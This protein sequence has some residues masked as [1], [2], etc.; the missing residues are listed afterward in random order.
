MQAVSAIKM[1]VNVK[2]HFIFSFFLLEREI[3]QSRCFIESI[4]FVRCFTKDVG[5]LRKFLFLMGFE[6]SILDRV[7]NHTVVWVFR[8]ARLS[9]LVEL[10]IINAVAFIIG[11]A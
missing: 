9:P 3:L 7:V 11:I 8:I 5:E 4:C 6:E 1:I 2:I 10:G